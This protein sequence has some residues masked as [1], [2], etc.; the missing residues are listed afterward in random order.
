L[1]AFLWNHFQQATEAHKDLDS[2][3][4]EEQEWMAA[5]DHP[6]ILQTL[7][8][9]KKALWEQQ[10]AEETRRMQEWQEQQRRAEEA[11]R[12]HAAELA[13][14]EEAERRANSLVG[15]VGKRFGK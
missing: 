10:Q 4:Q 15:K 9:Y 1:K 8:D 5:T 2:Q 7:T 6:L 13:A 3:A 12:R 11:N 14:Q